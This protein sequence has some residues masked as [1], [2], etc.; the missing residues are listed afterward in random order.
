MSVVRST[1]KGLDA[2]ELS[3]VPR[4]AMGRLLGC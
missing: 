3:L 1:A 4:R 2:D